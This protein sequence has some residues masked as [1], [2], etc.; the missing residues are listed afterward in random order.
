MEFVNE[1][2]CCCSKTLSAKTRSLV[3]HKSS[4]ETGSPMTHK[5]SAEARSLVTQNRQQNWF[6][7]DHETQHS[8]V[9]IGSLVTQNRQ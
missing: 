8:S 1:L 4:V 7:A 5:L 2:S 9:T 3:T 6:M